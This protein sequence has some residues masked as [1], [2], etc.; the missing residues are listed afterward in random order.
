MGAAA[1]MVQLMIID[2]HRPNVAIFKQFLH[3]ANPIAG[4]D[5]V[6]RERCRYVVRDLGTRAATEIACK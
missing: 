5:R 3:R 4:F 6:Q 1:I 2:R